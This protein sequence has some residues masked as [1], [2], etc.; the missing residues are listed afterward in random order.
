MLVVGDCRAVEPVVGHHL[1][2]VLI[3]ALQFLGSEDFAKLELGGADQLVRAGT[4]RIAFDSD[5]SYEVVSDDREGECHLSVGL[6]GFNTD[7]GEQA[8]I[9][10]NFEAIAQKITV[11][12]VTDFLRH[13]LAQV[14]L[15][16]HGHARETNLA[17]RQ[18]QVGGDR[19]QSRIRDWGG[20]V[21]GRDILGG[22]GR[23]LLRREQQG[24][25]PHERNPAQSCP[26]SQK[27]SSTR[28]L[29]HCFDEWLESNVVCA[30]C[31]EQSRNG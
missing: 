7:I 4:T 8:G 19:A 11:E 5:R 24:Q 15:L 13:E 27:S 25:Q 9:K 20:L 26:C 22:R 10:K 18:A 6:L 30:C 14:V 17:D 29:A 16:A 12:R 28:W 2:N 23:N 3:G 31:T 1:L 21:N